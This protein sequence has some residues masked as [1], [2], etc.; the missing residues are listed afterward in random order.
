M[1]IVSKYKDFYDGIAQ[2]YH[3]PE[4]VWI[5]NPERIKVATTVYGKIK[6]SKW[7]SEDF[8][9]G[10]AHNQFDGV[11]DKHGVETRGPHGSTHVTYRGEAHI[12][13]FCGKMYPV[14]V[15][16]YAYSFNDTE[17]HMSNFE[18]RKLHSVV[19]AA[20]NQEQLLKLLNNDK[21]FNQ[22]TVGKIDVS[23]FDL[24]FS[25][26]GKESNLNNEY[27]TPIVVESFKG[28]DH[29]HNGN[30]LDINGQLSKV[31]FAKALDPIQT[32][33]EIYMWLNSYYFSKENEMVVVEDKYKIME[34]GFDLKS[35]FRKGKT[36]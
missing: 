3:E 17:E 30:Y 29:F 5:R 19:G 27:N 13:H 22:K 31:Q 10:T 34:H 21:F 4:P 36:K 20:Y 12:V 2:Q 32:F 11:V 8:S 16:G 18:Y 7:W 33:Q 14:F 6:T 35:S 28:E 15:L 23:K 9:L 24:F 25:L 1:K 26:N